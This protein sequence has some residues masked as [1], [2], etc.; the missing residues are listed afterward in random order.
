VLLRYTPDARTSIRDRQQ[1]WRA[2]RDNAGLFAREPRSVL[3]KIRDRTD[4]ARQRYSDDGEATVW[5]L[6]LPKTRHHVYDRRYE[7]AGLADV[8]LAANAIAES[9]PDL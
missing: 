6:L 9:G 2:H 3:H 4:V 8:L 7:H 1:W 5:R